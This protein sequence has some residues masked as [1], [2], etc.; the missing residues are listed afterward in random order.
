MNWLRRSL[1]LLG[2]MA[3]WEIGAR[4]MH[5]VLF[6]P[7][8]R[9]VPAF[10]GLFVSGEIWDDIQV[11]L[12]NISWGFGVASVIGFLVAIVIV[13]SK[14][15]DMILMPIVDAM[16]PVAALTIFP[17]IILLLGLGTKSKAFVI[18][19][20]SWPAIVLN[21]IQGIRMVDL[22]VIEAA[23]LDGCSH[24]G[25]LRPIKIP[26]AFPT[27]LTG[28]RIGLSGGW[29]SL[30][31]AEMLGSS[32]GLGYSILAYSQTFRFPEMYAIVILI[33]LIGLGM[34][35]VLAFLQEW[36]Q[37]TLE[38]GD[39]PFIRFHDRAASFALDTMDGD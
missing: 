29:I 20:T 38:G 36:L 39:S 31:S 26:L 4:L 33:A 34:N 11:S 8:S 13:Q 25:L 27:I 21:T 37:R 10:V 22:A 17:L 24:W 15:A 19:W 23:Q 1:G 18:F 28:F 35:V 5:H 7:F 6:P 12:V 3:V 9:V 30:V 32:K 2:V 14:T 16:R